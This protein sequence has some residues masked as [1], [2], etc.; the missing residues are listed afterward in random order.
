MNDD[1]PDDYSN[2]NATSVS[3]KRTEQIF[4]PTGTMKG[5]IMKL[6]K[7]LITLLLCS[8]FLLILNCG[9]QGSSQLTT[10]E[11]SLGYLVGADIA[12]MQIGGLRDMI[13]LD[14]FMKGVEDQLADRPLL[15]L[16]TDREKIIQKYEMIMMEKDMDLQADNLAR[17]K[18]FIEEY[19]QID[20]VITTR[21]GLMYTVVEEGNGPKPTE[22]D[23][24]LLNYRGTTIDGD[25][26]DSSYKYGEPQT[27]AVNGV[28][29][30]FSEA[31]QLMNV[32][33]KFEIVIPPELAYGEESPSPDIGP[34]AVLIFRIELL[35]IE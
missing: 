4:Q 2:S 20:D 8:I 6:H 5:P 7:F 31:L 14:A 10:F 25:E 3:C 32:G 26:F 17:G 12:R 11:D 16:Y 23:R 28:I 34:N 21:S 24:V 1:D 27:L 29:K 30:G 15:I 33:S 22:N 35:D 9:N 18:E 13:D 19:R